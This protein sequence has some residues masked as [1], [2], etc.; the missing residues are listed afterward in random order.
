MHRR[1][2]LLQTSLLVLQCRKPHDISAVLPL[3]PSPTVPRLA[4]LRS[5]ET[6]RHHSTAMVRRCIHDAE[7]F[8]D[9]A[10]ARWACNHSSSVAPQL[11]HLYPCC[12]RYSSPPSGAVTPVG[13][14]HSTKTIS[15]DPHIVQEPLSSV[16]G[17][18]IDVS[19][20]ARWRDTSH[21]IL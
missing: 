12:K 16:E 9:N 10:G 13:P 3:K 11:R 20:P 5:Y 15:S 4:W 17:L 21:E 6:E 18:T 14:C 19:G 1:R 8:N 7:L 2:S